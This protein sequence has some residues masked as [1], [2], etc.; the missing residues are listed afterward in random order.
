M[1]T[2]KTIPKRILVKQKIFSGQ[3]YEALFW[4]KSHCCLKI[5][6]WSLLVKSTSVL[7]ISKRSLWEHIVGSLEKKK[8]VCIINNTSLS[9]WQINWFNEYNIVLRN[10]LHLHWIEKTSDLMTIWTLALLICHKLLMFCNDGH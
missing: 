3:I 7:N 9:N 6:N 8:D 2:D 1:H 5:H 10:C 4:T